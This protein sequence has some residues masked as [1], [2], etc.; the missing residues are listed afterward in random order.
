M[1]LVTIGWSPKELQ[2]Q[3][4]TQYSNP[5]LKGHVCQRTSSAEIRVSTGGHSKL[6]KERQRTILARTRLPHAVPATAETI[7][8]TDQRQY[9]RKLCWCCCE[10]VTNT[11]HTENS[12]KP[13]APQDR[14][15][16]TNSK[17]DGSC[18][19]GVAP[20]SE[21]R[22]THGEKILT[23][24]RTKNASKYSGTPGL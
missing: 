3:P 5:H 4:L 16:D 8:L 19:I 13:E 24:R 6:E 17:T 2:E 18:S 14:D 1:V 9:G 10:S 11:A 23:T 22:K 21:Q 15:P 12:P 7:I 20:L